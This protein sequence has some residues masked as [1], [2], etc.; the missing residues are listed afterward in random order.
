MAESRFAEALAALFQR[1]PGEA[2]LGHLSLAT[3]TGLLP[4]AQDWLRQRLNAEPGK[5][6]KTVKIGSSGPKSFDQII[7]FWEA[8]RTGGPSELHRSTSAFVGGAQDQLPSPPLYEMAMLL[9][10][11]GRGALVAALHEQSPEWRDQHFVEA[12]ALDLAAS[13]DW[14]AALALLEQA[15]RDG[16]T[17][18]F[19]VGRE[20][21]LWKHAYLQ[22]QVETVMPRLAAIPFNRELAHRAGFRAWQLLAY[23]IRSGRTDVSVPVLAESRD[24]TPGYL[25]AAAMQVA[26]LEHVPAAAHTVD[27]LRRVLVPRS[28]SIEI[29]DRGMTLELRSLPYELFRAQ[30]FVAARRRDYPRLSALARMPPPFLAPAADEV[31]DALLDEGD[32]RGA[33]DV[34]AAHDP[35]AR[36]AVAGFDDT[37]MEDYRRLQLVLAVAAARAGDDAA[38]NAFLSKHMSTFPARTRAAQGRWPA[39]LLAGVAEGLLPRRLLAMLLPVFSN[40]Y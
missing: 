6:G 12:A 3:C 22:G 20:S 31:I 17:P 15:H 38:A 37:R 25:E 4:R 32:W 24:Q 26:A 14:D 29:V 34:A 11:I 36:E 19:S 7:S 18:R 5:A 8:V 23:R 2:L 40:P 33:A 10:T 39:M 1:D 16:G 21:L 30:A 28:T 13:E 35:R 27:D 9:T